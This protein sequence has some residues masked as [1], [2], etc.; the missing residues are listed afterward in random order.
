MVII[1]ELCDA[2]RH[3]LSSKF[4]FPLDSDIIVRANQLRSAPHIFLDRPTSGEHIIEL[5]TAHEF[6]PDYIRQ[7]AH[8]YG[9]VLS[10]YYTNR[11][12]ANKWFEEVISEMAALT[13]LL[14]FQRAAQWRVMDTYIPSVN[15]YEVGYLFSE[16]T[17]STLIRNTFDD[18]KMESGFGT[19]L[20]SRLSSLRS[21]HNNRT[22]H[23][24]IIMNLIDIL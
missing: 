1:Q 22:D 5:S 2:V 18:Q 4:E 20:Q 12:G 10:N 6:L 23:G 14:E 16:G 15:T 17:L 13:V 9:H 3:I 11:S 21:D 7:F 24:Q 8:E 19:W